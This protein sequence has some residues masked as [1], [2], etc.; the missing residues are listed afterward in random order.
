MSQH[1]R[2]SPAQEQRQGWWGISSRLEPTKVRWAT[3]V[4]I[5]SN[6]EF[7]SKASW[8]WF[9]CVLST[10]C[11]WE[12]LSIWNLRSE[13]NWHKMPPPQ[14]QASRLGPGCLSGGYKHIQLPWG[15]PSVLTP[16]PPKPG[17]HLQD[18]G[19]L[20]SLPKVWDSESV[21][22]EDLLELRK[23]WLKGP[24]VRGTLWNVI[25]VS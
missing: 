16:K 11:Q 25:H 20:A 23:P 3:S 6:G 1:T 17:D 10:K 13:P 2:S 5:W 24:A 19:E 4:Y 21:D 8:V 12:P 18:H 7:P 15:G 9:H 22:G 14:P